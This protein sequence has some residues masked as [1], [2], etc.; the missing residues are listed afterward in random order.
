MKLVLNYAV[1]K[2][3]KAAIFISI[4][5]SLVNFNEHQSQ[6]SMRNVKLKHP[7]PRTKAYQDSFFISTT[8]M[9]NDLS[10]ELQNATS[11]Y[12]FKNTLKATIPS[13]SKYFS[14]G[15][16]KFN[17]IICQLRNSKSQLQYDLHRD[18]LA[19]SPVCSNC[20]SGVS[21]TVQHY[22]F[23]CDKYE[24]E[25][26]GLINSLLKRPNIYKSINELNTQNLLT[27]IPEISRA[28]NEI[29][30]DIIIEFI[31]NTCRFDKHE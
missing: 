17:I 5:G 25:R 13:A 3:W 23:E 14:Y 19:E 6:Y 31:R 2:G 27:G 11:L 18:R 12:S 20:N 22:F 9:W 21:E 24:F 28:E 8:D 7:I 10:P 26:L 1:L 29:L 15:V 16:R 30:I 4:N